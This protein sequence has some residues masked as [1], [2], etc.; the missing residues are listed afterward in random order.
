MS[1][2]DGATPREL[3]DGLL[4]FACV[5]A[6]F[7]R[8]QKLLVPQPSPK[9]KRGLKQRARKR[10]ARELHRRQRRTT[11]KSTHEAAK[12]AEA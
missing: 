10:R 8:E 7:R 5:M 4:Q 2:L 6:S 11:W 3:L 12:R 9:G 1:R